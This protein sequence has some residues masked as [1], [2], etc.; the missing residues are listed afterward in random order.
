MKKLFCITMAL[1]MCLG[2]LG[3][4]SAETVVL[5]ERQQV[6][7]EIIDRELPDILVL[8]LCVPDQIKEWGETVHIVTDGAE[9]WEIGNEVVNLIL[10][11][12]SLDKLVELYDCWTWL[13]VRTPSEY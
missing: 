4:E 7:G 9:Q 6:Y 8:K 1:F 2:L 13:E 12:P 11:S 3:C 5:D 10:V